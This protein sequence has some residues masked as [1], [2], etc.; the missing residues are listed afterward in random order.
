MVEAG[1]QLLE[2]PARE[3]TEVSRRRDIERHR[4][5]LNEIR[6]IMNSMKNLSYMETR[7]ISTF[8]DV[9]HSIVK[10][11]QTVAADF[12]SFYP[13][14]LTA[15]K[16]TP[17][18]VNVYLLIGTERGFC[19]DFNHALRRHMQSLPAI[20]GVDK[21][22]LI[23]V[24]RRLQTLLQGDDRPLIFIDG[25]SIVE[26]VDTVLNQVVSQ[27]AS[28]QQHYG[29]LNLFVLYHNEEHQLINQQLLPPF[30]NLNPI[31]P[32]HAEPPVLNLAPEDFLLDLGYQYL[33]LVL[34]EIL[35]TS[36][37]AE[38]RQRV[39]HLEGAIQH[40]EKQSEELHRQSNI[41]R[42]EEIIEEIEVILLSEIGSEQ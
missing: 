13:E 38:S 42:Q 28:I 8:L 1:S 22:Q 32:Q 14:T 21:M 31:Q 23:C 9:Q 2:P 34:Y 18:G 26:E 3:D 35:Y 37:M 27:L 19:G 5:S 17:P 41:L 30:Q 6:D 10:H 4:R 39:S 11:I 16:D 40:M 25:A 33:F 29:M 20:H 36:L 15:G 24:G 7:K 12:L